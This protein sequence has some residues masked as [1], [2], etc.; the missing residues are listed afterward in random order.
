MWSEAI[1][2]TL[3]EAGRRLTPQRQAVLEALEQ[4]DGRHPAAPQ[5]AELVRRRQPMIS[6]ATVYKI[7]SELV[8]LGLLSAVDVHDGRLHY[9]LNTTP[10]AHAVCRSCGRIADVPVGGWPPA[11]RAA[12]RRPVPGD[13]GPLPAGFRLEA[14]ELVLR[15]L[16]AGCARREAVAPEDGEGVARES[17]EAT[18]S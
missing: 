16:C 11:R 17:A 12:E 9:D 8:E 3:R 2:A 1:V 18:S 14:V 6:E 4:L 10:H 15:G 7:L 5:V 13:A